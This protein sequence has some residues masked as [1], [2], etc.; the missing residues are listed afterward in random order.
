MVKSGPERAGFGLRLRAGVIARFTIRCRV[1]VML[2]GGHRIIPHADRRIH[3]CEG[4]PVVVI[5][6]DDGAGGDIV[7]GPHIPDR[8][9]RAVEQPRWLAVRQAHIKLVVKLAVG[10]NK[11]IQTAH[12]VHHRAPVNPHLRQNT[13]DE[14]Q[15]R[16]LP[17]SDNFTW[18]VGALQAEVKIRSLQPV[19]TQHLLNHLRNGLIL[20]YRALSGV[21]QKRQAG[22]ERKPVV[23]LIL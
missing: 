21:S 12:I 14:L 15:V 19:F 23:R 6:R 1:A 7:P 13:L 2:P 18:W 8:F 10:K 5:P 9:C 16:L 20:I 4:G 22:T 11:R 17:L 3:R